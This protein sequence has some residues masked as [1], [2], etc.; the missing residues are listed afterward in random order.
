M[1]VYEV[2]QETVGLPGLPILPVLP[3]LGSKLNS[4]LICAD[5]RW[6]ANLF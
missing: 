6:R 2:M 3:E 5:E 1:T 4:P